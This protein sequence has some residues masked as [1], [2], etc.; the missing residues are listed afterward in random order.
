MNGH[1]FDVWSNFEIPVGGHKIMVLKIKV[2]LPRPRAGANLKICFASKTF[3]CYSTRFIL[4]WGYKF[5]GLVVVVFPRTLPV[6]G[7]EVVV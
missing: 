4:V 2:V 6:A 7:T 3:S 1:N 5:F